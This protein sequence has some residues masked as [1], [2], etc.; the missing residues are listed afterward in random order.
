M[1]R[2]SRLDVSRVC[3]ISLFI[4]LV[5]C[6]YLFQFQSEYYKKCS[7]AQW[8]HESQRLKSTNFWIVFLFSSLLRPHIGAAR[9]GEKIE[10][11]LRRTNMLLRLLYQNCTFFQ[12]HPNITWLTITNHATVEKKTFY[13]TGKKLLPKRECH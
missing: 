1:A 9:L 5:G 7:M 3:V 11:I 8:F 12:F 10:L 13:R 6:N 2:H 4:L